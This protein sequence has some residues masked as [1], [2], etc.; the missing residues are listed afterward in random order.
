MVAVAGDAASEDDDDKDD[1]DDDNDNSDD[2]DDDN[3]LVNDD[4]SSIKAHKASRDYTITI[5]SEN[6]SSALINIFGGKMTTF[7]QL[8]EE[9]VNKVGSI[10]GK[11][12]S[13]WT[14]D[15]HLPGGNFSL[16]EKT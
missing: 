14:S 11:N 2:N 10:L 7:R 15:V 16:T 9:V 3:D 13:P 4:D 6:N 5:D 12:K 8:S 1:N